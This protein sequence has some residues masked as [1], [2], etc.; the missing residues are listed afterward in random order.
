MDPVIM[1][2]MQH[3][4]GLQYPQTEWFASLL[5]V[6]VAWFI[7]LRTS[8]PINDR[9]ALPFED[10]RYPHCSTRAQVVRHRASPR[11]PRNIIV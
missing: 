2:A 7:A 3:H 6:P 9:S 1:H 10:H 5:Q 11:A 4:Y 8:L